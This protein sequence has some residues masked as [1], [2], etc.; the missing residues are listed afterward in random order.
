MKKILYICTIFL[1][2]GLTTS[3]SQTKMIKK[4]ASSLVDKLD[5]EIIAVNKYLKLSEEQRTQL[6]NLQVDRLTELKKATNEGT[7]FKDRKLINKAYYKTIYSKIL[8]KHQKIA[9][10]IGKQKEK[11]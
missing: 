6:Y 2:L 8:T 7:T 3:F 9:L 4:N 1:G 10:K 11:K 5:N